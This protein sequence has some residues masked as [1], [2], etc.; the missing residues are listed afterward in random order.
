MHNDVLTHTTT[1]LKCAYSFC[2]SEA[3]GVKQLQLNGFS[4]LFSWMCVTLCI[5][6]SAP[7]K[8]PSQCPLLEFT[9]SGS[10]PTVLAQT[11]T[12]TQ[13]LSKLIHN[14]CQR[15]P[16]ANCVLQ[17][18]AKGCLLRLIVWAQFE[19]RAARQPLYFQQHPTCKGPGSSHTESPF[20]TYQKCYSLLLKESVLVK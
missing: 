6:S 10:H 16:I 1:L 17:A 20:H 5:L 8:L 15:L 18:L 3:K 14:K 11:F 12:Y 13:S 2:G 7:H 9:H 19:L 4:S